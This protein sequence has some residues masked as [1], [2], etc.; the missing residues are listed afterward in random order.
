MNEQLNN[1][2]VKIQILINELIQITAELDK[3]EASL[4][5]MLNEEDEKAQ[6]I[7]ED[8]VNQATIKYR[9]V[10]EKIYHIGGNELMRNCIYS[11]SSRKGTHS[12]INY[13]WSN[14]GNWQS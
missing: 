12:I 6:S 1:T 7:F 8:A 2:D 14:I 4:L 11:I 5:I 13:A 3:L 10:G 9:T